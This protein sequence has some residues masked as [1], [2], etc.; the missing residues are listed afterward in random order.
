VQAQLADAGA[1]GGL[2]LLQVLR[3]HPVAH[4]RRP[5]AGAGSGGGA[6]TDRGSVEGGEQRLLVAERIR[7]VHLLDPAAA[8]QP[9]DAP[10]RRLRHAL[11]LLVVGRRQ[12]VEPGIPVRA[13]LED[14]VQDQRVEMDVQVQGVARPLDEPHGAGL[15]PAAGAALARAAPQTTRRP[16]G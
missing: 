3:I 5:L 11:H 15:Q 1:A 7:T 2:A 9:L 16:R 13:L 12:D 6:A 14:A 10:G 4:P 8:Q